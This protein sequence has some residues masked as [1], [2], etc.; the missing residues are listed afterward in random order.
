MFIFSGRLHESYHAAYRLTNAP[1]PCHLVRVKYRRMVLLARQLAL[2]APDEH[3]GSG[4]VSACLVLQ[5]LH[6]H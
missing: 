4:A 2:T 1:F 3:D 6:K 5:E